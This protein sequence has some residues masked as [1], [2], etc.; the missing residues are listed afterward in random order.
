MD[1]HPEYAQE[2]LGHTTIEITLDTYS[3]VLSGIGDGLSDAMD[4]AMGS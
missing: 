3:H 2:L 4:D 1:Q